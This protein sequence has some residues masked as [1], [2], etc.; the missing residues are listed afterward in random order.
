MFIKNSISTVVA[1]LCFTMVGAQNT[2]SPY[3]RFG[4]GQLKPNT[5]VGSIAMGG[6]ANG[7]QNPDI[8][9]VLNPA[10]YAAITAT[11]FEVGVSSSVLRL[12]SATKNQANINASLSYLSFAFPISKHWG[13]AFGLLPYS[14]VGYR[15]T[16]AKTIPNSGPANYIYEGS[17]GLSKFFIG[18]GFKLSKNIYAGINSSFLFGNIAHT[19]Y[20]EIDDTSGGSINTRIN[21]S[22]FIGDVY[23]DYG[24]QYK[25]ELKEGRKVVLGYSG[26][27]TRN[28]SAQATTVTD[29]YYYAGQNKKVIDTVENI[30]N[31]KTK[32]TVPMTHSVGLA[33]QQEG[34]WLIGADVYYG[35]W[36]DY[37]SS[38]DRTKL[39]N[40]LGLAM[41]GFIVPDKNS[42]GN[43]L[44][45]IE[46]RAGAHAGRSF[47][48]I[49]NTPIDEWGVSGGFG[50]PLPRV[51]SKINL[52]VEY[53]S[54]GTTS[55]NLLKE[56]Y[57]NVH[58]SFIMND[59]WFN[60]RKYE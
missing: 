22:V 31:A 13:L 5:F 41:G 9:N 12:S 7:L 3:S 17:G 59:S 51:R 58:L 23:F 30:Q 24:I 37:K 40:S 47:L 52:A 45:N 21:N 44:K 43:Y 49:N 8:V 11:T 20:V 32:V 1:L 60:R 27:F 10:S 19:R 28:L 46:Y 48:T 15:I 34:S 26:A 55:N 33:L 2:D 39:E 35:N 56:E 36:A 50:L 53:I 6:I 42:I 16:D 25:K 4:I 57:L 18:N 29:R 54:R 14:N 38:F